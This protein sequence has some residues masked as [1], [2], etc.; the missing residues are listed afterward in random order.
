M[1]SNVTKRRKGLIANYI[2]YHMVLTDQPRLFL[3]TEFNMD[4]PQ[5]QKYKKDII[6]YPHLQ[7]NL[8]KRNTFVIKCP[9]S[10]KL[11]TYKSENAGQ[12]VTIINQ[13][14]DKMMKS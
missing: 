9:M 10:N 6:L 7:A 4:E 12:W 11:W 14:T 2:N 13:I 8:V 1:E 5:A 3:L